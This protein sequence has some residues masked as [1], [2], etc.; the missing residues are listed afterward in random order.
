MPNHN[1]DAVEH[2]V[3]SSLAHYRKPPPSY[4]NCTICQ[5]TLNDPVVCHSGAHTFCR[6]CLVKWI[7]RC[8]A[9]PICPVDRAPFPVSDGSE[10]PSAQTPK[11]QIRSA[12]RLVFDMLDELEVVC[13]LGCGWTGKACDKPAHFR[14]E[15]SEV[16]LARKE[17]MEALEKERVR[18]DSDKQADEGKPVSAKGMAFFQCDRCRERVRFPRWYRC[19][20]CPDFDLCGSCWDADARAEHSDHSF[21]LIKTSREV[22]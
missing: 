20:S 1:V 16:T 22:L 18:E 14:F 12:P 8:G 21:F 17:F 9:H 11:A 2:F 4:L 19:I 3:T 7:N 6:Q 15:C 13:S 10:T 5:N